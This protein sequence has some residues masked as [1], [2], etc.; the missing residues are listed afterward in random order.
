MTAASKVTI[1]SNN[2]TFFRA[3]TRGATAAGTVTGQTGAIVAAT[4]G[5]NLGSI[6]GPYLVTAAAT[7]VL[8]VKVDAGAFVAITLTAGA[9]RTAAQVASDIN[10]SGLLVGG[11]ASVSGGKLLITSNST[12]AA[13]AITIDTVGNGS[14]ANTALGF[15]A[16]GVTGTVTAG[17]AAGTGY[18]IV[19]GVNDTLALTIDGTAAT[20]T[21]AN[22]TT[23]AASAVTQINTQLNTAL[24]TVAQTYAVAANNRIKISSLTTGSSSSVVVGAGNVNATLGFSAGTSTG[25]QA[26]LGY[27]VAGATFVLGNTATAAPAVATQIDAGGSSQSSAFA[28]TPVAY[29]GD[30]QTISVTANDT[31]GAPHSLSTILHNDATNRSGRSIDSALSAINTAL[32]QSN[33][34]TLQKVVA[35]KENASGVEKIRFLDAS[36]SFKISVG[37][38]ANA[39][40]VGSQG[41]TDSSSP[42]N[43]PPSARATC[44]PRGSPRSAAHKPWSAGARTSS[45][46]PSTWRSPS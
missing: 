19:T 38:T 9:A 8:R 24:G 31:T 37:T 45:T 34:S 18:A 28:F 16:G 46:M 15:G 29:G 40:G 26:D 43:R 41:T 23:T 22:G 1:T 36:G 33:D 39:T 20:V 13:S 42:P 21:L 6:A 7:D 30:D 27:G 5:S 35:V 25:T 14:T 17:A 3:N 11:T 4:A 2:G 10:N 32:Q 44:W 12:G